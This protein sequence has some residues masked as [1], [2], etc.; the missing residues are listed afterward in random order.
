MKRLGNH[1]LSALALV[2]AL[3]GPAFAQTRNELPLALWHEDAEWVAE[4]LQAQPQ[5]RDSVLEHGLT[6]IQWAAFHN[7][8]KSVDTLIR[9]GSRFDLFSAYFTSRKDQFRRQL[10]ENPKWVHEPVGIFGSP[11]Y[12]TIMHDDIETARF[13]LKHGAK[14]DAKSGGSGVGSR[15]PLRF[16][17]DQ[18]SYD[19]ANLLLQHGAK[20]TEESDLYGPQPI[21]GFQRPEFVDLF[22][23]HGAKVDAQSH[24]GTTALMFAAAVAN[25]RVIRRLLE[26]G[27]DPAIADKDG[28]TPLLHALLYYPT[29]GTGWKP[30]ETKRFMRACV[31]LGPIQAALLQPPLSNDQEYSSIRKMLL[32]KTPNLDFPCALLANDIPKV[33]KFLK[34]TPKLATEPIMNSVQIPP[35]IWAVQKGYIEMVKLLVNEYGV[36][37]NGAVGFINPRFPNAERERSLFRAAAH[38]KTAIVEFLL[39]KK[40]DVDAR[41]PDENAT[42][43]LAAARANSDVKLIRLLLDAGADINAQD[44]LEHT[45]LIHAAMRGNYEVVKLLLDRGAKVDGSPSRFSPLHTAIGSR[46]TAVVDLL[47]E[48]GAPIG[49]DPQGMPPAIHWAAG[50]GNSAEIIRSLVKHGAKTD[51][52]SMTGSCPLHFAAAY[53]S[54]NAAEELLALKANVNDADLTGI[55]PL[56]VAARAGMAKMVEFLLQH[57]ADAKAADKKGQR[58]LDL[59]VRKPGDT[60]LDPADDYGRRTA[61]K[62]LRQHLEKQAKPK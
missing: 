9:H 27:A 42:P 10:C 19:V 61:A 7:K 5:L 52:R 37:P 56:H 38:R 4:V 22:V 45:A 62:F 60:S 59:T 6:S 40:V 39:S 21:F 33:K 2:L 47:L 55:T 12:W 16:A 57:G 1:V 36:D 49:A 15:T 46:R 14:F 30:A 43:L 13:L 58:P 18:N 25:S 29:P 3:S 28:M 44:R 11:L 31:R 54:L 20:V 35:I 41:D 24:G 23:R 48:R 50:H 51:D 34:A 8:K 53:G 32:A 17:V 26:L